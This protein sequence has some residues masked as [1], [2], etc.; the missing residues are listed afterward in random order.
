M[1]VLPKPREINRYMTKLEKATNVAIIL[2]CAVLVGNLVRNYYLSS[3]PNPGAKPP[4]P[5]GAVV[6]LPGAAPTGQQPAA[7]TLVMALSKN[8]HFCQESMG[9]YQ[10]L[11][12]LKNSTPQGL[13]LVAVLPEKQEEAESYLKEHGIG[14][15]AVIS[16]PVSE[17]G[18]SGT[19]TLL[20]LNQESKLQ[21]SWVGKLNESQEAQVI[22]RLKKA[23]AACSLPATTSNLRSSNQ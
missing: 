14:A 17:I 5:K 20:L 4:T 10:K 7:P 1:G 3:R 2:A 12:A 19:P 23:C 15:D 9:F 21:E 22:D 13:R 11:T 18:V 6:K 8:C 16:A